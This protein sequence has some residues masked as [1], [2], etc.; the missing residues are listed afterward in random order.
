MPTGLLDLFK[1]ILMALIWLFFLRVIRAVWAQMKTQESSPSK[2]TR[3][4]KSVATPET[5]IVTS[6]VGPQTNQRGT[7][8]IAQRDVRKT[9]KIMLI[10]NAFHAQ[11]VYEINGIGTVGRASGCTISLGPDDYCSS[12]HAR[13]YGQDGEFFVEDL[14]ST[15]S[16]F[17][18]GTKISEPTRLQPGDQITV[19]RSTLEV[20]AQ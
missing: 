13:L 9:L 5:T 12:V 6:S 19:G 14:G 8:V 1:Y 15:N 11:G 4:S 2:L 7:A 20:V 10:A 16:T 18:N 17:V 3:R